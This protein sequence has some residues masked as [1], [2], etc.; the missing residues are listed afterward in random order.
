M[1]MLFEDKI[2]QL[3]ELNMDK[4]KIEIIGSWLWISG[5]GTFQI[6]DKLKEYGFFFSRTKKAWFYNGSNRKIGKGFYKD[7]NQLKQKFFSEE[8]KI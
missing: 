1:K 7:I 3:K 2:N 5:N 8:V 4:L 6:K